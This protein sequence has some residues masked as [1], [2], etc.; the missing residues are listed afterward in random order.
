M[1]KKLN[2]EKSSLLDRHQGNLAVRMAKAETIII[3]Q[4]KQWMKEKLGVNVDELEKSDRSKCKRSFT[5]ILIKN[6][7]ANARVEELRDVFER[8]GSL[9]RLELGPFN[10]LAL[11][12]FEN[13]KQA[14]AAMKNLAYHKFNYLMPL[15]LEYAPL[16]MARDHT[17]DSKKNKEPLPIVRVLV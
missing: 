6:L 17:K 4:T 5:A 16:S 8:Y 9:K 11:A 1:A 15:Y 2:I 3:S 13:E 7:P 12:E 14:K 10:T